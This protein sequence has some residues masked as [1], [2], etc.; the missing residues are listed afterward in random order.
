MGRLNKKLVKKVPTKPIGLSSSAAKGLTSIKNVIEIPTNLA[1]STETPTANFIS[2]SKLFGNWN[3]REESKHPSSSG[4]GRVAKVAKLR[5]KERIKMRRGFLVNK[6]VQ[7][8]SIKKEEKDKLSREKVVIVKD[9][10]PLLDNL[11]EIATE[12][13]MENIKKNDKQTSSSKKKLLKHTLKRK[14]AK[15]Q[16]LKDMTFLK[17]ASKDPSYV[18]D[19]FKTV[20][21]HVK[22]SIDLHNNSL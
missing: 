11:Q 15:E 13:E 14:K 6:L 7:S 9:T 21:T 2:C 12:I 22:N 20:S 3:N 17:A 8:E 16:F 19:P 4:L 10:K 18:A 1:K 5:K